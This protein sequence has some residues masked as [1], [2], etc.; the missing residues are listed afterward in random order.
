[1]RPDAELDLVDVNYRAATSAFIATSKTGEVLEA[2][3]LQLTN[4]GAAVAEFNLV[5]PKRPSYKVEAALDRAARYFEA[6]QLPYRVSVRADRAGACRE[7]CLAR[8]FCEVKSV[9]GMLL[10][11]IPEPPALPAGLELRRVADAETLAD[12][13]RV[14]F[15]GF[16]FPPAA[17]PLFLTR[18]FAQLPQVALFVGY[19]AGEPASSAALVATSGVAGVYWVATR[20]GFRGRGYG[21]ALTWRAVRA[22]GELGYPLASLQASEQGRPIYARMGFVHDRDYAQFDSPAS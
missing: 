21:E 8:G 20:P 10:A 5:F 6:K 11:P 9:P 7:L 4:T 13:Q 18:E 3:D 12:F 19:A 16:G 14:A 22:G 15:E 17:A 1:M 2:R